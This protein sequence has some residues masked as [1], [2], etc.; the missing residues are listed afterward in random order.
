MALQ[1]AKNQITEIV[2]ASKDYQSAVNAAQREILSLGEEV[3]SVIGSVS[4][5]INVNSISEYSNSAGKQIVSSLNESLD[6]ARSALGIVSNDATKKIKEIVDE[7][8]NYNNSL[9]VEKREPSLDYVEV[10]LSSVA[11]SIPSYAPKSSSSSG[12]A[13][14]R[15]TGSGS[16]TGNGGGGSSY[17]GNYDNGYSGYPGGMGNGMPFEDEMEYYLSLLQT[18]GVESKQI[19]NWD[20]ITENFINENNLKSYVEQIELDGN[21]VRC[22]LFNKKTYKCTGIKDKIGFLNALSKLINKLSAKG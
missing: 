8:N 15:K 16:D 3:N 5:E 10:N 7:Y 21:I 22:T 11:G 12:S 17:S 14:T 1:D 18:T 20:E 4:G 6:A 9:E 2:E 13:T 19:E